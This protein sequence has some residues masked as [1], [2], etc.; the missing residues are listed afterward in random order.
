MK[1]LP[2]SAVFGL[3]AVPPMR[4]AEDP[5]HRPAGEVGPGGTPALRR[6]T[7]WALATAGLL[8]LVLIL[9]VVTVLALFASETRAIG[10]A[11][12]GRNVPPTAPNAARP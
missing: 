4:A 5:G 2:Q 10:Q 7:A 1:T 6:K 11:T 12:A 3:V 9:A 8:G